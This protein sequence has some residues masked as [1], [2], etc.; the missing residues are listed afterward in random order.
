MATKPAP[1]EAHEVPPQ[2]QGGCYEMDPATG[3]VTRSDDEGA[4]PVIPEKEEDGS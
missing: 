2:A 3:A 4:P 1:R